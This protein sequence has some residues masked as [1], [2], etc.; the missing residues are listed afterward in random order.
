VVP[1][2]VF[3]ND[4]DFWV[5]P[6]KLPEV[7]ADVYYTTSLDDKAKQ[8]LADGGKVF[9]NGAGK[10]VKGKEI[11]QSFSPIFWNTSWFKMRPPHTMG[12]V[13][14]P[15]APMFNDFPNVGY[16][17]MAWWDIFK[18]AQ[19]MHLE[20]FP[21]GFRALVQPVDT[22]FMNRPLG[23]LFEAKVGKGSIIVSSADLS[24]DISTDR[25]A[26]R[27]LYYSIMKYMASAQFK[28]SANIELNT[29][30]NI[31]K[32]PSKEVFISYTNGVPDELKPKAK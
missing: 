26:A 8:V 14:D 29:I 28:P 32:T 2:T 17:E 15:K 21:R 6:E 11:I 22:W 4:W 31:F 13:C 24:T 7:K 30:D 16:S 5:Y 25:P 19:V 1:N 20:D 18:N 10:V 27:Q 3:V 23:I 12:F 9:L